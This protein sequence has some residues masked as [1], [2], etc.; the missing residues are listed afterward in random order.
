MTSPPNSATLYFLRFI[1]KLP[2][3]QGPPL[4]CPATRGP[5]YRHRAPDKRSLFRWSELHSMG[6]TA[7]PAPNALLPRW[8]AFTAPSTSLGFMASSFSRP[9]PSSL[10]REGTNCLPP[11]PFICHHGPEAPL[12]SL[13]TSGK[14]FFPWPIVPTRHSPTLSPRLT[15]RTASDRFVLALGPVFDPPQGFGPHG[16]L[17][18]CAMFALYLT[19]FLIEILANHNPCD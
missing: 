8:S 14:F 10:L 12:T 3:S 11:P 9:N 16:S 4:A 15:T 6:P 13:L 5:I 7:K 1:Q 2:P 18:I 19:V 17:A